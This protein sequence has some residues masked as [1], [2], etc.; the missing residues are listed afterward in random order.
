MTVDRDAP[1]MDVEAD[2]VEAASG[3]VNEVRAAPGWL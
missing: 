3:D 1:P 2:S